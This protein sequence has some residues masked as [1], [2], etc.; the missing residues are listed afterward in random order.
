MERNPR[1]LGETAPPHPDQDHEADDRV[2]ARGD[3]DR[4][5][6]YSPMT[7][8]ELNGSTLRRSEVRP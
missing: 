3:L 5:G 4:H 7:L 6:E 1:G 2:V 8:D